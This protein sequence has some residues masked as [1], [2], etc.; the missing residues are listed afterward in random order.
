V[1]IVSGYQRTKL[2]PEGNNCLLRQ[3]EGYF[4]EK[5]GLK[6]KKPPV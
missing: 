2:K 4:G 6:L 5:Q 1:L 3:V